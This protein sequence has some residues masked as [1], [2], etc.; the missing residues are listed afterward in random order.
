[1]SVTASDDD[2]S[3]VWVF[4]L[5][6]LKPSFSTSTSKV[7]ILCCFYPCLPGNIFKWVT[8]AVGSRNWMRETTC[9]PADSSHLLEGEGTP[10]YI[11]WSNS[12]PPVPLQKQDG[13]TLCLE[14]LVAGFLEHFPRKQIKPVLW[15]FCAW[16]NGRGSSLWEV[17]IAY[18][19]SWPVAVAMASVPVERQV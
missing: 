3:A 2:S 1:M 19:A 13:F 18:R 6:I 10:G 8:T 14:I 16:E 7:F 15:S 11:F 12:A 17:C 4:K 5:Y 9:F